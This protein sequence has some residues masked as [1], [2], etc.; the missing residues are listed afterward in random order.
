MN[1]AKHG[2]EALTARLDSLEELVRLYDQNSPFRFVMGAA[3]VGA[4]IAAPWREVLD[5]LRRR[6]P[7]LG[8]RI[9]RDTAVSRR[10]YG[11]RQPCSSQRRN[12]FSQ[13][14]ASNRGANGHT[15]TRRFI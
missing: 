15:Q 6:H 5:V 14:Y 12:Q 11:E 9:E 3:F 7:R 8:V 1:T 10:G 13:A 4:G 2:A